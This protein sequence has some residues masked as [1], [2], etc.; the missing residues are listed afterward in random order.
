MPETVRGRRGGDA[1]LHEG[2]AR[3]LAG[4]TI[5]FPGAALAAERVSSQVIDN[6]VDA[7]AA[8][9]RHEIAALALTLGVIL[10]AVVT[11]IAL[12]RTRARA[13]RAL[14][15]K[16]AEINALREERDRADALLF[17]EPQVVVVWA[18]GSDEPDILGDPS[19]VT[20]APM[21]RRM[22]AFG[23]WLAAEHAHALDQA[24]EALRARGEAFAFALTTLAGHHVEVEGRAIGGQVVLR[25]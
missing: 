15:A 4:A 10:F 13:A 25:I 11:A 3:T 20:H 24:V 1:R 12:L 9:E 8:L 2:F 18:A 21:P 7:L 6:Y 5:L 23:T 17:S 16:Q 22:L 19:L 14:D